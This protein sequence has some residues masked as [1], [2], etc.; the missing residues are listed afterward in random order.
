MFESKVDSLFAYVAIEECPD[1]D[2][3][4]AFGGIW[5]KGT[6]DETSDTVESGGG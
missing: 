6:D 2:P 4:Q 1:L 3:A 5:G